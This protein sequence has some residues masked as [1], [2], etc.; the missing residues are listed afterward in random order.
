MENVKK[1]ALVRKSTGEP[2]VVGRKMYYDNPGRIRAVIKTSWRASHHLNRYEVG[3]A[4]QRDA[5][6]EFEIVE[7]ELQRTNK[8]AEQL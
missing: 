3:T 6:S 2:V 5:R 7:F 8:E 1:Y 4:E